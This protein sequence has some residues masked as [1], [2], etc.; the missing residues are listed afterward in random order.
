MIRALEEP[1]WIA[2]SEDGPHYGDE[3]S[4]AARAD[5]IPEAA[6]RQLPYCC[7]VAVCDGD[8]CGET[9]GDGDYEVTHT[10]PA[11]AGNLGSYLASFEW[12]VT[13][14]GRVYCHLEA[15]RVPS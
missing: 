11:D 9:F 3:D 12:T 7:L 8:G 4:A 2:G 15:E 5:G 6:V 1:C 10:A 14:D 13:A